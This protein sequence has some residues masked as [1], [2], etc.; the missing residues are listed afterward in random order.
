MIT[1]FHNMEATG[2]LVNSPGCGRGGKQNGKGLKR[3]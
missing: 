2:D 1:G 3:K